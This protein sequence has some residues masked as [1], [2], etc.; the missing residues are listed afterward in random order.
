[1]ARPIDQALRSRILEA[2]TESFASRGYAETTMEQIGQGAGVTKGGVYFHFDFF[3]YILVYYLRNGNQMIFDQ[4]CESGS[5]GDFIF[6]DF[7][8]GID[9]ALLFDA[10]DFKPAFGP[11]FISARFAE[12]QRFY[13]FALKSSFRELLAF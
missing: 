13:Q 11:D 7:H 2:A 6:S 12:I 1:M 4:Y 5:D 8:H 9:D 10:V 3:C